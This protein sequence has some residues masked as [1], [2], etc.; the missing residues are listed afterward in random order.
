[1]L[2]LLTSIIANGTTAW[3]FGYQPWLPFYNFFPSLILA[4]IL[5]T[6]VFLTFTD[7]TLARSVLWGAVYLTSGIAAVLMF[8]PFW[9]RFDLN[10]TQVLFGWAVCW[11]V[12]MFVQGY[13]IGH[14]SYIKKKIKEIEEREI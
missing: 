4:S 3:S 13:Y 11:I 12:I 10:P 8:F 5:M 6:W 1:M 2:D 7:F 9:L 14:S